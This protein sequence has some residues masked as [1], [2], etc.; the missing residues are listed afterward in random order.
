M[1]L[2]GL[3][4]V[5]IFFGVL[6]RVFCRLVL[7]QGLW[8]RGGVGIRG[9]LGLGLGL[10]AWLGLWLGARLGVGAWLGTMP[11]IQ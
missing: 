1:G 3:P 8:I 4:S 11:A 5:V 7:G 6:C 9:R 2:E 10:W